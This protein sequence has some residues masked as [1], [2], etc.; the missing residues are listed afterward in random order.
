MGLTPELMNP[1]DATNVTPLRPRKASN[2]S[3]GDYR[4]RPESGYNTDRSSDPGTEGLTAVFEVREIGGPEGRALSAAQAQA[5]RAALEWA[6]Q[7]RGGDQ[8]EAA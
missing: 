3:R 6:T 2:N 7:Q 4:D 1:D 5:V 8:Q